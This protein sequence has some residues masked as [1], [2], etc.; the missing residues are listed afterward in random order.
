MYPGVLNTGGSSRYGHPALFGALPEPWLP[1]LAE[2]MGALPEVPQAV[3]DAL[4]VVD[5]RR[6]WRNLKRAVRLGGNR[7]AEGAS[8]R[9]RPG[10]WGSL[11]EEEDPSRAWRGSRES[12]PHASHDGRDF[13]DFDDEEDDAE[14]EDELGNP[15]SRY[16][17]ESSRDHQ[18]LLTCTRPCTGTRPSS[19]IARDTACNS[20]P[21]R[22]MRARRKTK[23]DAAL[24]LG[25]FPPFT[26]GSYIIVILPPGAHSGPS[27]RMPLKTLRM[28][29]S[30]C[31][32]EIWP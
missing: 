25:A 12:T 10:S 8:S 32:T 24:P 28:L 15:T 29:A 19:L 23:V 31:S 13:D 20:R 6:G 30:F 17:S 16:V 4:L 5:L 11:P 26:T 3:R 1:V 21:L 27:H 14:D 7:N 2:P 18:R 9:R 22:V